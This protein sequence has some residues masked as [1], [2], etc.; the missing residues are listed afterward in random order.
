MKYIIVKGTP[1]TLDADDD[2]IVLTGGTYA[3]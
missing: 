1:E 3:A 2:V